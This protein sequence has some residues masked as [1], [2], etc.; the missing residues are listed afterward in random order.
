[1]TDEL[2]AAVRTIT[3]KMRDLVPYKHGVY[4][5]FG[6]SPPMDVPIELL[7][8]S[9]DGKRLRA[10]L[11]THNYLVEEPDAE[12][13]FIVEYPPEVYERHYAAEVANWKLGPPPPPKPVCSGCGRPL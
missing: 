5:T 1:M 9:E 6:G 3:I 4:A 8:W 12:L 2:K 13:D 11:A 7:G 10:L